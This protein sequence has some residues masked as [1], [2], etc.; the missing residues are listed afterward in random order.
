MAARACVNCQWS[1]MVPWDFSDKYFLEVV[2]MRL[3]LSNGLA[4]A[5]LPDPHLRVWISTPT[6]QSR[7]SARTHAVITLVT[8]ARQDPCFRNPRQPCWCRHAFPSPARWRRTSQRTASSYVVHSTR[9][10]LLGW[11]AD[12][13]LFPLSVRTPPWRSVFACKRE[14]AESQIVAGIVLEIDDPLEA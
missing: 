9:S 8:I 7:H 10:A 11:L 12:C 5:S 1:S 6:G 3:V 2:V 14:A 13:E 4:M